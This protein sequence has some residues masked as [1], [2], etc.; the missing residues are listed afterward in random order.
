M[1]T[2]LEPPR[3]S[4]PLCSRIDNL[5]LVARQQVSAVCFVWKILQLSFKHCRNLNFVDFWEYRLR[6]NLKFWMLAFRLHANSIFARHFGVSAEFQRRNM[7]MDWTQ[8]LTWTYANCIPMREVPARR[9]M[10]QTVPRLT[11]SKR[12]FGK[13]RSWRLPPRSHCRRRGCVSPGRPRR[14]SKEHARLARGQLEKSGRES[15]SVADVKRQ[16]SNS[17]GRDSRARRDVGTL[18]LSGRGLATPSHFWRRRI[19]LNYTAV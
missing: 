18:R 4:W 9:T 13:S 8:G 19:N 14:R 16:E 15:V 6:S 1:Q 11:S 12:D 10:S 5:F 3:R 17:W 2:R 7:S